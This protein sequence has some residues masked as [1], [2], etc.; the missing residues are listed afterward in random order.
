MRLRDVNQ[1][2]CRRLFDWAND[3]SLRH[4]AINKAIIS[5]DGHKEWFE[6]KLQSNT[7]MLILEGKEAIGQVRFD[8]IDDHWEIDYS[9]DEKY[10]GR[11]LGADLLRL[12]LHRH[13]EIK[14]HSL[15]TVI[16]RVHK[17]NIPSQKIFEKLEFK[18]EDTVDHLNSSY[19]VYVY[20]RV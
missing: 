6:N 20:R 4:N 12:A 7:K 16:G 14:E 9:I 5:W 8:N 10:R 3:S 2:D 17:D 13:L 1:E 19:L 11:G 18:L 15:D